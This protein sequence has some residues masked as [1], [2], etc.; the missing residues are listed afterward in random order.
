MLEAV[1]EDATLGVRVTAGEDAARNI[2]LSASIDDGH[3]LARA[4]RQLGNDFPDGTTAEAHEPEGM[5]ARTPESPRWEYVTT[6]MVAKSSRD[7]SAHS[8]TRP[9]H[10]NPSAGGCPSSC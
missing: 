1:A 3:A 9:K 2:N 10:S 4:E 5:R 7:R 6:L 8:Q